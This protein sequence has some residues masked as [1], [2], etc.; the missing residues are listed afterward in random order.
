M[1]KLRIEITSLSY[2][3]LRHVDVFVCIIA[4]H[5]LLALPVL[6]ILLQ[7]G[8]NWSNAHQPQSQSQASESFNQSTVS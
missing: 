5:R 8:S 3:P 2:H 4:V 6:S 1:Q 7:H